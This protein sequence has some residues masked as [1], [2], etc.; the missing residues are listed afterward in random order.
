VIVDFRL[1]HPCCALRKHTGRHQL[2]IVSDVEVS[3]TDGAVVPGS[4]LF[5]QTYIPLPRT[6]PGRV[7]VSH[8]PITFTLCFSKERQTESANLPLQ[9]FYT[10]VMSW[11]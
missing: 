2:A 1:Q 3:E 5:R 9:K 7:P 10:R 4:R 6:T 11:T 8:V